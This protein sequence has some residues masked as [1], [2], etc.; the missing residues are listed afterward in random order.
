MAR[1]GSPPGNLAYT[2]KDGRKRKWQGELTQDEGKHKN[3]FHWFQV[4]PESILLPITTHLV[5]FLNKRQPK[6]Q[7]ESIIIGLDRWK[8]A[9]K[10]L[11]EIS[12]PR[13]ETPASGGEP[14]ARC[15]SC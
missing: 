8:A 2:K 9:S 13:P 3:T 15:S 6:L 5:H 1:G 11:F 14:W 12:N 4:P 7:V 10:D